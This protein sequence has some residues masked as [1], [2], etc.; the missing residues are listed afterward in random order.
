MKTNYKISIQCLLVGD[1]FVDDNQ[2]YAIG[3]VHS[4]TDPFRDCF[5]V[6]KKVLKRF[7]LE[8]EVEVVKGTKLYHLLIDEY[9]FF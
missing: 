1:F 6:N 5:N 9:D 2:L 3:E 4:R 7:L 8:T